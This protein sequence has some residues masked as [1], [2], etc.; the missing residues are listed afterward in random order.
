MRV[1]RLAPGGVPE[2]NFTA[3][4]A[5]TVFFGARTLRIPDL[6]E[7]PRRFADVDPGLL[8]VNGLRIRPAFNRQ[9]VMNAEE[10][11]DYCA[12]LWPPVAVP[13]HYVFSAGTVGHRPLL[14][15]HGTPERFQ[16]TPHDHHQGPGPR[17]H[18]CGPSEAR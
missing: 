3:Q 6:D 5:G 12:V 4:G 8:P 10:A 15:Y 2:I 13:I 7:I 9:V 11:G 1:W 14:K 16:A 17:R 18:A